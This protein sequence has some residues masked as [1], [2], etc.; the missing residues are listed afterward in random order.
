MSQGLPALVWEISAC[1]PNVL[2][3]RNF[4]PKPTLKKEA[5]LPSIPQTPGRRIAY[6]GSLCWYAFRQQRTPRFRGHYLPSTTE[7][8]RRRK[9]S[10][11]KGRL[12]GCGC[13][14]AAQI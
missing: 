7:S 12:T 6:L 11:R 14:I 1:L 8:G 5:H 4:S 10:R 2:H 3:D 9:G 13:L